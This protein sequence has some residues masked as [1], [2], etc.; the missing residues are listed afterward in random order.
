M[1][2]VAEAGRGCQGAAGFG[3]HALGMSRQTYSETKRCL[4]KLSARHWLRRFGL[5][6]LIAVTA[7]LAP[8]VPAPPGSVR[9]HGAQ[10]VCVEVGA[11]VLLTILLR[12]PWPVPSLRLSSSFSPAARAPFWFLLAL[13]LWA[14][15]SCLSAPSPFAVQGM[16]LLGAGILIAGVTAAQA[17]HPSRILLVVASVL[18]PAVL[19]ALTG[20]AQ[21][22]EGKPLAVGVLQDHQ[23]FGAFL[24]IS[25]P[26][27]LALCLAPGPPMQRLAGLA[28]LMLCVIGLWESQNRSAWLG[29][30]MALAAFAGF[31]RYAALKG[32]VA[33]SRSS[34]W[35]N[36]LVPGLLGIIALAG[37]VLVSP[38][39]DQL[40]ARMRSANPVMH[41]SDESLRWRKI[42]WVGTR[43]M[44][45]EKPLGGW[46]RRQLS[47]AA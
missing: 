43:R 13:L 2:I 4:H 39:Q 25:V 3:Y 35:R 47:R 7:L 12:R 23:L 19:A 14:L 40:F 41:S 16:L 34:N 11:V 27:C 18:L 37:L 38:N 46:G 29:T 21:L 22:G 45:A 32:T 24:L 17:T 1:F 10:A 8:F 26:L 5:L 42:V 6:P 28:A 33:A 44:I 30:L 9:W 36:L 31:W 20:F 15:I